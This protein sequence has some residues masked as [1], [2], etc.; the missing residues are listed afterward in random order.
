MEEIDD[1][2]R[3]PRINLSEVPADKDIKRSD[4]FCSRIIQQNTRQTDR[5]MR[6]MTFLRIL[7]YSYPDRT[8]FEPP[9]PRPLRSPFP[10]Y[11]CHRK[12]PGPPVF[13]P[14]N[15]LEHTR[16]EWGN[17]C[18]G[19]C[20]NT[21]L[22]MN[23]HTV[24][25]NMRAA[26]LVY[27]LQEE[28]GFKGSQVGM[29]PHF[30]EHVDYG[31]DLTDEAFTKNLQ[32]PRVTS[33]IRMRPYIPTDAVIE[34]V[35]PAGDILEGIVGVP[36]P[37]AVSERQQHRWEFRGIRQPSREDIEVRLASLERPE[38]RQGAYELYL[39]RKGGFDTD[40]RT[41]DS[42][43]EMATVA[44]PKKAPPKR[45]PVSA[46]PPPPPSLPEGNDN[47]EEKAVPPAAPA[48]APAPPSG[49]AGMLVSS[50]SKTRRT[51][52]TTAKP[53]PSAAP[54]KAKA[55]APVSK[56]APA[57]VLASEDEDEDDMSE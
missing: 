33:H 11:Q 21:Y 30:S 40:D 41:P 31:G 48:P 10:C 45:K 37:A 2:V 32:E 28:Y 26:D 23:M 6:C 57:P 16:D 25:L 35:A 36:L 17:F 14:L 20:A 49:L 29:A 39:E 4:N 1:V 24:E 5:F 3:A 8:E 54:A 52:T 43:S 19:P 44:V 50:S 22:H 15:T 18:S 47:E 53:K 7:K 46:P 55:P 42:S 9:Y 27:Y 12:F 56:P 38:K 13:L 34:V 51:K